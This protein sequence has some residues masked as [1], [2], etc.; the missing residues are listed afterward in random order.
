MEVVYELTYDDM[1]GI[2]QELVYIMPN[3]HESKVS[4]SVLI[5]AIGSIIPIILRAFSVF[6]IFFVGLLVGILIYF[7]LADYLIRF[8]FKLITRMKKDTFPYQ[9]KVVLSESDLIYIDY[10]KKQNNARIPWHALTVLK[11]DTNFFYLYVQTL[12]QFIP[13]KKKSFSSTSTEE[14]YHRILNQKLSSVE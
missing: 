1:Q 12:N 4:L 6:K 10:Q 11:E 2:A 13:L 8:L 7:L 3:R 5:P 14:E 9:Y